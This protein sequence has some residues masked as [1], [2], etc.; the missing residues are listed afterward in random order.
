MKNKNWK[1]LKKYIFKPHI[2]LQIIIGK[3]RIAIRYKDAIRTA[4]IN[5]VRIQFDENITFNQKT[6]IT[7]KGLVKIGKWSSFGYVRGGY[8]YNG[9]SELQPRYENSKIV[10]GQN[11]ATNNNLFICSAREVVIGDNTLIGEGVVMIDHDAHGIQPNDRKTSIGKVASIYIGENV[12][13]G[14]RVTILPG[15]KIGNN[16]VIGAGAVIKGEFPANTIIAGN[17][18]KVIKNL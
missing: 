18:A 6:I 12:W 7:G 5:N 17:P 14:S 2:G 1:R 3:I 11:V 15:T 4:K 13:I 10:I 8:F 9:I 16:S